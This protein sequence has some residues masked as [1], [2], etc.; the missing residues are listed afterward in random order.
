LNEI[1]IHSAITLNEEILM[2]YK[3]DVQAAAKGCKSVAASLLACSQT[4][5]LGGVTQTVNL[6]F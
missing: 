3:N 4:T 5:H 2:T 6:V 1:S